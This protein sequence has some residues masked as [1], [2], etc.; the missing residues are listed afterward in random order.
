MI[1][2]IFFTMLT[3]LLQPI[4]APRYWNPP[5]RFSLASTTHLDIESLLFSFG[6]GA[7]TSI[8]YEVTLNAKHNKMKAHQNFKEKIGLHFLSIGALPVIFS[9]LLITTG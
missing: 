5:S 7:I 2:V 8:L 6:T 1:W 3:G 9:S 4:F